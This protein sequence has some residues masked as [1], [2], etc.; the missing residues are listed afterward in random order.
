[1]RARR[2]A[3]A[4]SAAADTPAFES[5][6]TDLDA[7]LR[8]AGIDDREAQT[9]AVLARIRD[10]LAALEPEPPRRTRARTARPTR[11]NP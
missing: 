7:R 11:P 4:R 6:A 2:Q 1:M 10:R 8:A 9:Q 3:G 5:D